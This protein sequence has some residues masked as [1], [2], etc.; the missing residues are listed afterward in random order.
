ME[1]NT[2]HAIHVR[3]SSQASEARRFALHCAM[4][5][6]FDDVAAGRFAIVVSEAASNLHKHAGGGEVIISIVQRENVIGVEMHALDTGCGMNNV[7]Q[8]MRDGHSTV[9][10]SG[11]GLG[12]MLRQADEFDIFSVPGKGTV[13]WARVWAN[14][15]AVNKQSEF[16]I[17][18]ISVPVR[19]ESVC[20][21]GW[22]TKV[23][24]QGTLVM[25]CDGLGHG[26]QAALATQEA[27]RIF[28]QRAD[29]PPAGLLEDIHRGMRST[30][31]AAIAI[32]MLDRRNQRVDYCGVGNIAG[33]IHGEKV[34][35]MISHNG[36]V[37]HSAT[38]FQNFSYAWP[39]GAT[40]L[41]HSDGL[42]SRL[43]LNGYVGLARRSTALI[44]GLLY[45]DFK[46]GRDDATVVA[47]RREV[48]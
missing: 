43:G 29:R 36:T 6:G 44:S 42:Q 18:G 28:L 31:G 21:D 26:P 33:A 35:F 47:I 19:G 15:T 38:K 22:I 1:I 37:G 12:A 40:I 13:V 20:G 46:R 14:K 23:E 16:S 27:K 30:R 4:Q 17:D 41:M 34:Q 39:Q 48:A 10:T 45:R 32:A 11:T 25:V 7:Q 24:T 9:G 8:S 5:A 2:S 3:D